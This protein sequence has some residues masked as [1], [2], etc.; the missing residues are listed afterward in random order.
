[1]I[2]FLYICNNNKVCY[3]TFTPF[4]THKN[5]ASPVKS[6]RIRLT[7]PLQIVPERSA[8]PQPLVRWTETPALGKAVV[9]PRSTSLNLNTY[10]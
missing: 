9:P 3:S 5:W 7:A 4:M 1:M 6:H 8:T 10:N 2:H